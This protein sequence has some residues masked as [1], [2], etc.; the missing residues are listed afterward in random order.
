MQQQQPPQQQ[1]EQWLCEVW[2]L[3]QHLSLRCVEHVPLLPASQPPDAAGLV[4]LTSPVVVQ[5]RGAQLST[6]QMEALTLV[7]V[8]VVPP[9]PPHVRHLELEGYLFAA[10]RHGTTQAMCKVWGSSC[11]VVLCM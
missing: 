6:P 4:P 8:V 1:V 9:L 2:G 11:V 10:D 3:L 7:G 5:G